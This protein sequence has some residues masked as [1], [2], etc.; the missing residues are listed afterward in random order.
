[1]GGNPLAGQETELKSHK[2]NFEGH[3]ENCFNTMEEKTV[4]SLT[5]CNN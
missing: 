5:R 3:D 1:M 2:I 4:L